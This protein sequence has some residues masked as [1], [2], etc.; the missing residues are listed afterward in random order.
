MKRW[1]RAALIGVAIAVAIAGAAAIRMVW[2][3][4]AA[5]A[6]GDAARKRG[7]VAAA[8]DAWRAA[9][10]DYL[11]F[12][13]HVDAA[14]D[15]LA[16]AARDAEVTGDADTALAAWRAI[17][18]ASRATAG[19]V[20]PAEELAAEA[21]RKIAI[22]MAGDPDASLVAG[23]TAPAR[24]AYHAARLAPVPGP[25]LGMILIAGLG[26]AGWVAGL[27][28]LVRRRAK[29]WVPV[30]PVVAAIVGAALWMIGL[31]AA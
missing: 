15:R 3:G 16:T 4:R 11:P 9:A 17:R 18:S 25:G 28:W 19:L 27:V 31:Y 22:L 29:P 10:R 20:T 2:L 5:L 6:D 24:T 7:D 8:I 12:A 13:P 23:A 21:D 26:V 1:L 14:Y 30:P